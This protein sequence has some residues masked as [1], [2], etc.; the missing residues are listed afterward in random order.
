V[1]VVCAETDEE[2]ERIAA[3]GRM[4][5]VQ[6]RRGRPGPVPSPE[7]ALAFL[8]EEPDAFHATGRRT[9]VGS[10]QTV[11]AGLETVAAEY[12]ADE[13]TVVTIAYDH[14]ARR[15]SYELVAGA[16]S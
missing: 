3:S 1:S 14:A 2:A 4:A 6:L 13:V 7:T 16:F 12:G 15:R 8:A 5:F 10:P 11:R 9:V